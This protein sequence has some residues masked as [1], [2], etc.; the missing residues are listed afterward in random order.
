[1]DKMNFNVDKNTGKEIVAEELDEFEE[2]DDY[3]LDDNSS[4]ES[5][6]NKSSGPSS[7]QRKAKLIKMMFSVIVI[8]ILVVLLIVFVTSI[9]GGKKSYEE[10]EQI[11]TNAAESYFK[12]HPE[13]LP[14]KDG[15]TQVVEVSVLVAEGKMKELTKYTDAMCSGS[16]KVQKTGTT[17]SYIPKLDCGESY[18]TEALYKVVKNDNKVVSTGYGLYNKDGSLVFRGEQVNNYVQLD[19]ALWRIVKINSANELVLVMAEP[20]STLVPW[21]DRY[22]QEA[23]YNAGINNYSSS[24]I[25][26]KLLELYNTTDEK[27]T[28]ILLSDKDK[29]KIVSHNSCIAKRALTQTGAE[30]AVECKEVIRE[31]K[32]SLLT[33]ADFMNASVDANCTNPS[34]LTCQNYNYLITDNSWWLATAVANSSSETYMVEANSGLAV[35]KGMMYAR[36]RP[37]VHLNSEVMYKGGSGTEEDP[38]LVK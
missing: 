37:V 22:N 7:E 32:L 4:N 13:N 8:V 35:K 21:D 36:I 3:E 20:L 33:A 24:R 15:G 26:E 11:M 27:I 9:S 34:S 2:D 17:Y 1:M 29:S 6:S 28:N 23:N 30:Q 25:K 14:K 5:S 12:D 38:Y 10:I 18:S 31:Q 16:V 19:S